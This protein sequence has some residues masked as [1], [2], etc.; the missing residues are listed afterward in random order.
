MADVLLFH[1]AQG[2]TAGVITFA[3]RLRRAG[4][5]VHTPDLY[6]GRTFDRLEAGVEHAR[7]VGFEQLIARGVAAA[8][9]L[10]QPLVYAGFSLG[11][12]PAQKLAQLRPDAR[13][14][15]LFEACVPAQMFGCA[16]PRH[17]PLQVHGMDRDHSFV[18]EGDLAA[19]RE[20]VASAEDAELFLYAG[21][22]HLFADDS[23]PSYDESAAAL[24]T[25][26]VLHFL[27]SK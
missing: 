18:E 14:A 5:T 19:A 24:L 15:L 13:G 4:H 25:E 23:L 12:M 22:K 9:L 1:H 21:D 10:P 7:S 8:E 11:V 26:R 6:E 16:W 27:R 2:C 20:L 17:V 3:E